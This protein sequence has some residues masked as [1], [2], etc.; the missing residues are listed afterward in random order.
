MFSLYL[1]E[2]QRK[3]AIYHLTDTVSIAQFFSNLTEAFTACFYTWDRLL[4]KNHV[5]EKAWKWAE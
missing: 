3:F 2:M 4:Y 5:L 1:L